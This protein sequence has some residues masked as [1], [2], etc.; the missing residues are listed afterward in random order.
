[1]GAIPTLA[2]TPASTSSFS[3]RSRWRG[4]AVDGSVLR[5]TS[6]SSVGTENVTAT[7][8]LFDASTSTSRSRTIMG[9]RVM[10]E[11]GFDASRNS[12]RQARVSL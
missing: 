10:I 9:P 5:H 11:K 4:C 3:A 2:L 1:M 8:A 6:S 12:S 7:D